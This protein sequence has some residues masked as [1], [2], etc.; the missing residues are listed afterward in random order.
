M[1]G[2]RQAIIFINTLVELKPKALR[3]FN[4][5]VH[6]IG[7]RSFRARICIGPHPESDDVVATFQAF[8]YAP[9]KKRVCR[10]TFELG[11]FEY[12]LTQ[13]LV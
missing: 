5:E 12:N 2:P 8:L 10:H 13:G 4:V 11:G 1:I 9:L 3:S 7:R 6:V